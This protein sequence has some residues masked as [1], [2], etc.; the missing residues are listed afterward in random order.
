M[1]NKRKQ[2][3]AFIKMEKIARKIRTQREN[4]E[5]ELRWNEEFSGLT[6]NYSENYSDSV[7]KNSF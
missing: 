4:E 6:E 3:I 2:K 1:K 7:G 5:R